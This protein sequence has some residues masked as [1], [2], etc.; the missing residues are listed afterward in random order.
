MMEEARELIVSEIS[1]F[2]SCPFEEIEK[3]VLEMLALCFRGVT[4]R[5]DS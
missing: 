5:I 4:P 3:R 2:F 1:E